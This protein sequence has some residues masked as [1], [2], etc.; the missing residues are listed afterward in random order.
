MS[1]IWPRTVHYLIYTM[2]GI[3]KFLHLEI[4]VPRAPIMILESFHQ[5]LHGYASLQMQGLAIYQPFCSPCRYR[6]IRQI[7]VFAHPHFLNAWKSLK[8][9]ASF[10]FYN[11]YSVPISCFWISKKGFDHAE[12]TINRSCRGFSSINTLGN[13]LKEIHERSSIEFFYIY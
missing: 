6:K 4:S 2:S 13:I 3:Y 12:V 7:A 5:R 9:I 1:R 10:D 8:K 11:E